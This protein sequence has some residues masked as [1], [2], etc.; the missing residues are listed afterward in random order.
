MRDSSIR[1]AIACRRGD[2][3]RDVSPATVMSLVAENPP[4]ILLSGYKANMGDRF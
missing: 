1:Q 3:I 4:R 2:R